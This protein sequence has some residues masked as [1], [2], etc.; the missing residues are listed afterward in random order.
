MADTVLTLT[1]LA[2]FGI[3]FLYVLACDRIIGRDEDQAVERAP[4]R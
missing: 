3:S 1:I 2:F 4:E